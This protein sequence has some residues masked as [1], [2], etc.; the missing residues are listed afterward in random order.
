MRKAQTHPRRLSP[1]NVDGFYG[2]VL[3][4]VVEL[5]IAF[6]LLPMIGARRRLKW[7]PVAEPGLAR[8][9]EEAI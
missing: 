2:W 4:A 9:R 5:R 7:L 8:A 1:H 6:C 3:I